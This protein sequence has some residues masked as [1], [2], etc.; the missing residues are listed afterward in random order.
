MWGIGLGLNLTTFFE[1][2]KKM[3]KFELDLS[4]YEVT[5]Q[6]PVTK[7]GQHVFEDKNEVYPLQANINAWLR[8]IG[9]FK[10]G[11]DIAEA[12][13]VAKQIRDYEGNLIILD[14]REAGVLK[15][16]VNRLVELT[17]E[18]KANLGGEVHEEAIVRVIKMKE[19]D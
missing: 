11:E 18:G 4:V 1:G 17:A 5:V 14:E 7:D 6:V 12:V 3:K 2:D 8:G 9:I 16:A 19:V 10:S 15:Y 13:S